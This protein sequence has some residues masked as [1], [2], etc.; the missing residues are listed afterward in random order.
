MLSIAPRPHARQPYIVQTVA[1]TG[2]GV[3]ELRAALDQFRAFGDA[4]AL[5]RERQRARSRTHLLELLRQTLFEKVAGE[6]L[7]NGTVD[8]YV[9]EILARRRDPHSAAE[10]IIEKSKVKS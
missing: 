6:R 4:S 1:T 9:E 2:K 7:R 8:R 10:E 5:K 3:V